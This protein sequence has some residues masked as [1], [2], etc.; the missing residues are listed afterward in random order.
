M[1]GCGAS[2]E[3]AGGLDAGEISEP[4]SLRQGPPRGI[5][6]CRSL[7][8]KLRAVAAAP[9]HRPPH[10]NVN[11][12]LAQA[13]E[14]RSAWGVGASMTRS[15]NS[16][17][18]GRGEGEG[19]AFAMGAMPA[20][21]GASAGSFGLLESGRGPACAH[22]CRWRGHRSRKREA[23][24]PPCHDRTRTSTG[25]RPGGRGPG[26]T[27][28]T[29]EA[30]GAKA[31]APAPASAGAG[32]VSCARPAGRRKERTPAPAARPWRAVPAWLPPGLAAVG[33]C[34]P[35][36][37]ALGTAPWALGRPLAPWGPGPGTGRWTCT[38]PLHWRLGSPER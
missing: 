2:G 30:G 14:A 8:K 17:D 33:P 20:G 29:V 7:K 18:R 37:W 22:D 26:R 34:S 38:A 13:R 36:P 21:A 24:P 3:A 19:G 5:V 10:V 11:E 23:P 6:S 9:I 4:V 28:R 16:G 25:M 32:L 15:M 1:A 31:G 27:S 35:G 12:C